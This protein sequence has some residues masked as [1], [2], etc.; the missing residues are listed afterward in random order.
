MTSKESKRSAKGRYAISK[1][2]GIA[3]KYHQNVCTSW[4]G[5]LEH[6]R[7]SGEAL[8]KARSYFPKRSREWRKW[9]VDHFDAS[10]ETAKVYMRIA[11]KWDDPRLVVARK[12]GMNLNSIVSVL[13]LLKY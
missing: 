7:K 3:N 4:R 13:R 8:V 11:R 1:L 6:A 10:Y 2:F 9:V 5:A 12:T